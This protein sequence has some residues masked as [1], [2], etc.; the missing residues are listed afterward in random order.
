MISLDDV[1]AVLIEQPQIKKPF[2]EIA[3]AEGFLSVEQV[4]R[5]LELQKKTAVPLGEVLVQLQLL[6]FELVLMNLEEY[7]D[8]VAAKPV[9]DD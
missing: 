7:L 3:V 6:D 2:G 4:D 5:L 9:D 1:S 8:I